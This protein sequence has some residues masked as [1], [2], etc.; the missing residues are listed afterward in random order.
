MFTN[1]L[2]TEK[3]NSLKDQHL[4]NFFSNVIQTIPKENYY[5][6][7]SLTE[8]SMDTNIYSDKSQSSYKQKLLSLGKETP[9]LIERSFKNP[10][11]I[12]YKLLKF[13]PIKSHF[14]PNLIPLSEIKNNN[15]EYK[16]NKYNS[17]KIIGDS[18]SITF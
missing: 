17:E 8:N 15:L 5:N 6:T 13:N 7:P 3:P 9:I 10:K 11:D 14:K 12:N 18:K 16:G 4:A 2:L 1:P